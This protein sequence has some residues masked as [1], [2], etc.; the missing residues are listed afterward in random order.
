MNQMPTA[1]DWEA[2][3]SQLE[4]LEN[5]EDKANALIEESFAKVRR[6][7]KQ[8]N[9][10]RERKQKMIAAGLHSM[11]ELDALEEKEREEQKAL[12]VAQLEAESAR[13][14]AGTESGPIDW[15]GS[16]PFAVDPSALAM[17]ETDLQALLD[18]FGGTPQATPGG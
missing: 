3:D 16:D 5:E 4:R 6:L 12:E 15:S 1:S 14:L 8:K 17:S 2:V 11:D 10:L 9:L 18:S 13:E 7:R